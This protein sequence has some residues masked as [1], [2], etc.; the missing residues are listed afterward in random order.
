MYLTNRCFLDTLR[1]CRREWQVN[2]DMARESEYLPNYLSSIEREP[3]KVIAIIGDVMI[4]RYVTGKVERISPEAPVPVLL[5]SHDRAVAGGAANVAVNIV[6]LGCD[7][8]L[9]GVV[10]ND[11]NANDLKS[12]LVQAGV[13]PAHLVTDAT[14]PTI[15]KTRVVS[16]RQQFFRIDQE[17]TGV[18]SGSLE[19]AL[20]ENAGAA[21]ADAD[22]VVISDY[23]K[24]VF[25]DR[26]LQQVIG[27]ARK[28]GKPVLVDPKRRTFDGY[29][30]GDVIKP[31]AGELSAAAG[32]PC[33][34]DAD[35][36]AA[37]RIVESQFDGAILV[38][39]AES[40]MS[41]IKR[42][43][44][45]KHFRS[46][47][48]EVADVSG[49]GDTAMAAL[50]VSMAEG[51]TL[52]EAATISNIAAA[53]AVSKFGTAIVSRTELDVALA[54][55][56][57][58]KH[59]P[60]SL[61]TKSTAAEMAAAWR[62]MGERVV[63]TNGC[64]DLIHA[65]HIELLTFAL[66]EGDRLIVG[67]NTDASVRKLKGPTRPIQTELD[68]ARIIGAL[69]AVDLVVL[70]DEQTPLSL[71]DAIGPDVLVKGADYTEDQVV[72]GD[73]VK[74]RGGRVALFPL[75]EGRSSSKIVGQIRS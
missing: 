26:V 8:R 51:R 74:L 2:G 50:A 60:G 64:F 55:A 1:W 29:R 28:L 37:A 10:G 27:A 7:A 52:E 4:D 22:I 56:S 67:L 31:N 36:E 40:G 63:F 53:V 70:F 24:G 16:G 72:G 58:P 61:V 19:D 48:L 30:G 9:V 34:S 65:G 45:A 42:G 3:R 32:A 13:S 17:Y 44:P 54:R 15:C 6:A 20:V 11:G 43:M 47:V 21:M 75:V 18:L 39:R 73:M 35:I 62:R 49:A 25:S 71:I 69:R 14:R 66:N 46:S 41:L 23:A 59:H 5:R 33:A 57:S 12:I 38:T 68:R